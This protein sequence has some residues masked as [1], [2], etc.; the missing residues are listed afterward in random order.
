MME[1]YAVKSSNDYFPDPQE[2]VMDSIFKQYERVLVESLVSAFGLDFFIKDRHGG[3]VDTIHNVRQIG[4]DKE[5]HYKNQSNAQAYENR[6]D[7]NSSEYHSHKSYIEKNREVKRQKQE[8]TLKDAYTNERIGPNQKSDLDHVISAKEIHEDRGRVLSGLKGSD[9]ANSKEN[10][11]AT[12]PHTNRTKKADSMDK[13]HDKYGQEYSEADKERMREK[14]AESRKS[15]ESKL[16]KEYYCS[17]KFAKDVTIAAGTVGLQMGIRQAMGFVFA[18]IWFAVKEEFK[19]IQSQRDFGKFFQSIGNAFK[20]GL[21]NAKQKYKQLFD[22]FF[23]GSVSGVLSSLTTTI[24]NMFFTTSKN[25]VSILRQSFASLT[26]AAKILF[27]NP[28]C[29]PLGEKMRAAAKVLATGASVVAGGLVAVAIKQTPLGAIPIVGG[30]VETFC[31]TLVSG[32]LSCTYLHFLD[33]STV[34]NKLVGMLNSFPTMDMAVQYFREQAGCFEAYAAELMKIDLAQ[35]KKEVAMYSALV[36]NLENAKSDKELN[37]ML[38]KA[39]DTI[40]A[41]LPWEGDFHT[42]MSDRNNVLVFE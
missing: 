17:P 1:C 6:G 32:I 29:L 11:Q 14:D 3:D 24:C 18:E 8:G 42:F 28:E 13:F 15:Y 12:N 30:I 9:L 37:I 4:Q 27:I 21:E 40:G 33:K 41:K 39:L 16:A 26:Q 31:G 34:I 7:Y 2:P 36:S 5:M 22:K 20:Q 10:L 35:F 19:S 38:R 23:Q 25:V